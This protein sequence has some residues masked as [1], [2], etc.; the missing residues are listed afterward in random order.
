MKNISGTSPK[1]LNRDSLVDHIHG[2]DWN[3]YDRGIDGSVGRLRKKI[4]LVDK[5]QPIKTVRN[6]GYLFTQ[7]VTSS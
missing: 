7:T 3:T 4:K 1:V 2:R 6:T 5:Y